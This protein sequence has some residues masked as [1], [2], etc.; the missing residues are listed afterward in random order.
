MCKN[1]LKYV[2]LEYHE[3]LHKTDSLQNKRIC[4]NWAEGK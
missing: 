1:I 3:Y 4:V 2:G